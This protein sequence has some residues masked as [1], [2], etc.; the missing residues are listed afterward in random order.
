[1]RTLGIISDTHGLL[2][3]EVI[4]LLRQCDLILHAG[5]IGNVKV[6]NELEK[7]ATVKA[8]RGNIDNKPWARIFPFYETLEIDGK[9][10][11]MIHELD[12][13]DIDPKEQFDL[14]VFGHTHIPKNELKEN[15][16]YFNPGSAG[17]KRFNLPISLGRIIINHSKLFGEIIH[18]D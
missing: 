14:V 18:L 11:Y 2:R 7:I 8:V 6:I 9:F 17:P 1:M 3:N 4:N 16:L 12:R 15:T 5:D 13:M 10:I